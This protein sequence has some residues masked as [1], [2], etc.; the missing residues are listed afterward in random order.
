MQLVF[1]AENTGR[2]LK[3]N[4]ITKETTVLLRNLQFPNGVSM[5]KDKSFFIFCEGSLGRHLSFHKSE[6]TFC[7]KTEQQVLAAE[8]DS[9]YAEYGT[10]EVF[11]I[12]PGFPDN[13]RTNEKGEFW[14]A[15]HC[16]RN[17]YTYLNGIYPKLRTFLLKL[18][19]PAR[20]QFL[21]H[22]GGHPHALIMKYSPD[23]E[24]LEVLEDKEGKVVK[25]V[26]EVEE[27]DGK[28]WMGSVLMPF[29][30]VY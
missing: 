29:M 24:I 17:L 21:M 20:L 28:L 13:V 19:V 3:Y 8:V 6:S 16:R 15:I 4:T 27:K 5:S 30:A 11:A 2:L 9:E 22:I 1:S 18:P 12:L 10:S 26:S 25:A 14:V 7:W 23:G